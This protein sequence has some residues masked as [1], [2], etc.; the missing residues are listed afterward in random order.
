MATT[1]ATPNRSAAQVAADLRALV[2]LDTQ[3]ADF[4]LRRARE[5]L[6][7]ELGEAPLRLL[8]DAERE[9]ALMEVRIQG[10]MML[11]DWPQVQALASR[12]A[13][14]KRRMQETAGVRAVAASVFDFDGVLVDPFSPGLR[15]IAGVDAGA[16]A[17]RRDEAVKRLGR[18]EDADAPWK[19]FYAARRQALA[20]A[21]VVAVA[22]AAPGAG[23]T[24]G[25]LRAEAARAMA[26]H[27]FDRLRELSLR[28]ARAGPAAPGAAATPGAVGAMPAPELRFDFPAPVRERAQALGLVPVHLES[29]RDRYVSI[30][31]EVWQP[32]APTRVGAAVRLAAQLG[33]EPSDAARERIQLFMSR[34]L[35]T[36]AGCRYLPWLVAE[37]ALVEGFEEPA[38]GGVE[39]NQPLLDALHL[40]RRRGLSRAELERTLLERG[41]AVVESLGLDPVVFRMVCIPPDL[42][43]RA[44]LERGW[45]TQPQ[46]TH[47]D[48]YMHMDGKFL[49]LAG[50]DVRFGGI[51]D[52]VGLG[53]DNDTAALMARLAVVQRRRLSAW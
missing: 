23:E 28:I 8:Q 21:P 19:G 13:D 51:Y 52:I 26:A 25:Q 16:L 31:P 53:R 3:F 29:I 33:E 10:A 48:G 49:A 39:P 27:D 14:L 30:Y 1:T 7:D 17:G 9:A 50:G 42:H 15:A 5:L 18:L 22:E 38:P 43:L 11:E 12:S 6:S 46:W 35:V 24:P 20:A 4:Y 2:P 37:D 40:G 32:S 47:F 41:G 44:G 34:A 45:G 36:S